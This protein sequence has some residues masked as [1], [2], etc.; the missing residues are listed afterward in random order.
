[1]PKS[2][3]VDP[4]VVRKKG[5]IKFK[6][7]PVPRGGRPTWPTQPSRQIFVPERREAVRQTIHLEFPP[8]RGA[9]DWVSAD[10]TTEFRGWESGVRNQESVKKRWH[11]GRPRG[12]PSWKLQL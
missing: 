11:F 9:L 1:M 8:E 6:P 2:I 4:K 12:K 3:V 5:S 7:I 10:I